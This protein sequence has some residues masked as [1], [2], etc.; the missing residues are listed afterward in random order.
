M[1]PE[2]E[3]SDP[4]DTMADAMMVLLVNCRLFISCYVN[5]GSAPITGGTSGIPGTGPNSYVAG[6]R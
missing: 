4:A 2:S 5:F 3:G 6:P 1:N